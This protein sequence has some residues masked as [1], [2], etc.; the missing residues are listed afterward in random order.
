MTID[1][2]G[3]PQLLLVQSDF[4][5]F[6]HRD[7]RQQAWAV[8]EGGLIVQFCDTEAQAQRWRTEHPPQAH[9]RKPRAK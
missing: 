6:T 7:G 4:T 8:W 1:T 2:T 3:D 5:G 9:P